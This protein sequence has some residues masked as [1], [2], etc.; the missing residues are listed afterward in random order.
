MNHNINQQI[1]VSM[2]EILVAISI[3]AVGLLGIAGLQINALKFQKTSAQRSE[4]MQSAYDI[5]ERMRA[6]ALAAKANVYLYT[7]A[8]ATTTATVPTVPTCVAPC[9]SAQIA[10]IDQAEWLLGL[11]RRL[12][13]GAGFITTNLNGG[14]DV[15]V[16]W[17]EP[18][19]TAVDPACANAPSAPGAGVRCYVVTFTP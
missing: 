8:Y 4:A 7:T 16:M 19:Y 3:I 2:V 9:T 18:S 17:K 15:T 13:G 12:L 1:G 14:F 6:N 5:S 11:S 10:A